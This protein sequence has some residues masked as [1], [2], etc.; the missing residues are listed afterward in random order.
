MKKKMIYDILSYN[1]GKGY[2]LGKTINRINP[3][4]HENSHYKINLK[5]S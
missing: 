3:V 5:A 1:Q 4:K 2:M